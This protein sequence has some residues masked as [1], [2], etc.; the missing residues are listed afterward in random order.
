M[1][2][3]RA[4]SGLR[5]CRPGKALCAA[6]GMKRAGCCRIF[7]EAMLRICPGYAST[8]VCEPVARARR[9]APP[10]G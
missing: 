8:A 10:P 4:L 1:S 6:P 9:S 7:P 5:S 2:G 3:L